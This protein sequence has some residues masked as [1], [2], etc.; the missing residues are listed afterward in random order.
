MVDVKI[1]EASVAETTKTKSQQI[2]EESNKTVTVIDALGRKIVLKRPDLYTV[3]IESFN[4][5]DGE[6]PSRYALMNI[7]K[8]LYIKSIDG[9]PITIKNKLEL[10]A[11]MQQVGYVGQIALNNALQEHFSQDVI[12]QSSDQED[13]AKK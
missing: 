5:L 10:K 1:N 8:Y 6:E 9:N 12:A 3:E 2:I 7:L 13:S 11:A 4:L